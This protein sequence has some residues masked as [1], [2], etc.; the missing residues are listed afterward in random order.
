[1]PDIKAPASVTNADIENARREAREATLKEEAD[2]RRLISDSF[3]PFVATQRE[4]FDTCLND[5]TCTVDMAREKLLAALGKGSEPLGAGAHIQ[6]GRDAREGFLQG[7]ERAL[8]AKMGHEKPEAGNEF[9]GLSLPDIAAAALS[10][11]G[12]SVRGL[13]R[14]QVA[15]RVFAALTSSD[16]PQLAS[17]VAG[18]VLRKAYGNYP[19]TW[20]KWAAAGSVSDFKIAP[21]IQIGSFNSLD[22]IV[23][24]GEYTY[25][26]LAEEYENAQAVTKGKAIALTRQ[27]IVNDDLGAFNRRAQLMGRAAARSVNT[28]AYAYLTSGSSNHGPTSSDTG[29]FFNATAVTTAGGHANLTSSG[30]AISTTSLG[31]GRAAM[32]KQK[33]KSLRETLNIEPAVLATSVTKED[34]ARQIM[35]SEAD[36][37]ATNSRV[38]NI[39]RGRLEVVS[40]PYLDGIGSALSW[41]L[42]ANPADVAAFEVVFLDGVQE[43]FVDETIDFDSDAMKF[44][45]RLDYGVAMGDWRAAYKNVGA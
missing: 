39:Y 40:D 9:N 23:E 5:T 43:P 14:N 25:G 27:M 8:L 37:A 22:T 10:R 32:R 26:T 19:S 29:Q 21:R 7:A 35:T 4:L 16:F 33:D 31:I 13:T 44:K 34:L 41:F 24:G 2:R 11:A 18:K 6:P 28:D 15:S 30:T 20:N 45:V 12:I 3:S 17:N 42:F 1:M 36:P 38:A